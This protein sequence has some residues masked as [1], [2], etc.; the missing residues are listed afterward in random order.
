MECPNL[1][2][3]DRLY[4]V[5]KDKWLLPSVHN[6]E[7]FCLSQAHMDCMFYKAFLENAELFSYSI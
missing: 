6:L 5:S 7:E 2:L 3:L 1:T 4:C